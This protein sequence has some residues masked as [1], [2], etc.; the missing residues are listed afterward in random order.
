MNGT[1]PSNSDGAPPALTTAVQSFKCETC[2]RE[3]SKP[4]ALQT[5][6][7]RAHTKFWSTNKPRPRARTLGKTKSRYQYY[8]DRYRAQGLNAKGQP[9]KTRKRRKRRAGGLQCPM[10]SKTFAGPGNLGM[11]MSRAHGQSLIEYRNGQQPARAKIG[12]PRETVKTCPVCKKLF[13]TRPNMTFHLRQVHGRSITEFQ[14]R[15]GRPLKSEQAPEPTRRPTP[16]AASPARA[17]TF[18]PVCGTNIHNVQT[19]V[20]F[21]ET[22]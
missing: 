19:A 9:Y 4:Q 17:V 3:F 6:V 5:H 1:E 2:G 18:C 14:A 13:K 16:K 12:R 7:I 20:N 8:R 15:G 11:H 21:G 10:C 22:Q